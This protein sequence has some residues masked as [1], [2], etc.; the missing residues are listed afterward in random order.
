MSSDSLS[1]YHHKKDQYYHGVNPV[2]VSRIHEEWTSILDIG[3]GTGQLGKV[4]KQQG[5]A[6]YGIEAFEDAAKQAEQTLDHVLCGNIEQMALP[7]RDEQFDCM[8]F[9]DVLEHLLD[10]WAA[11]KKVKPF[12]KKE[13][14]ILA[15]I[16]N[17]GHISTVLE[18]LAG[19][20][21][22]TDE[23]LMDQ[24]HLRFFTLHEIHALFHSA[25]FHIRE[26]ETIRVQHPSY[27]A[28]MNDLHE[29]L[30]KHGIRF[31]F[32]EAAT[33]YQYVVEAVQFNG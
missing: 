29:L 30:V 11:L 21:S 13:G 2:I 3:C 4:L 19:K 28:V 27:E 16:P 20:F 33:A 22:Y 32:N 1:Y 10:P 31:D 23:G 25:G 7:Y 15:S 24:T 6:I 5:R 17:I 18:L 12:L 26:L 9:G 14:V 8:I